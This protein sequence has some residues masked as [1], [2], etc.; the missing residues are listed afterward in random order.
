MIP[1]TTVDTQFHI[2]RPSH[3]SFIQDADLKL[4][5]LLDIETEKIHEYWAKSINR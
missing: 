4:A 1:E 2:L 5:F 3:P